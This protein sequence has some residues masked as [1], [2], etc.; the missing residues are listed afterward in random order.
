MKIIELISDSTFKNKK[1]L[2]ELICHNL[3]LTKS[4]LFQNY[5]TNMTIKQYEKIKKQY[6]QYENEKKPLEYILWF[7]E[8][9]WLKFQVNQKT[10]IPRPE[11]EY[12]IEAIN[13]YLSIV[14]L[15]WTKKFN[16]IDVWT[17]CGVLWISVAY[18]NLSKINKILLMDISEEA[19]QVTEKNT[20]KIL[21][22]YSNIEILQSN[23]LEY[24]FKNIQNYKNS[25][26]IIIWNLPY[27]PNDTFENE[28]EDNVKE[29]EPKIAFVGG[30]DWLDLYRKMLEQII[31]YWIN[32]FQFCIFLE[33]MTS[34]VEILKNQYWNFFEFEIMKTFHF[35]IK[36]VKVSPKF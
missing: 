8:F 35:N 30:D 36:I 34:Q 11:T 23:L 28:V 14:D 24:F 1:V 22:D 19:L 16:I 33:M 18:H 5:D 17:G 25:F 13:E 3:S 4:Q 20:S 29:R 7:V 26:N 27:I 6:F 2:K 32:K 9:G 10:L 12:M 31:N 21:A 15:R